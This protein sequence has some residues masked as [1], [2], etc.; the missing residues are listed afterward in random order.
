MPGKETLNAKSS[1]GESGLN[2]ETTSEGQ[3]PDQNMNPGESSVTAVALPQQ[4]L[5]PEENQDADL[6]K[7]YVDL[8]GGLDGPPEQGP[9]HEPI[10]VEKEDNG[11]KD[12]EEADAFLLPESGNFAIGTAEYFTEK[13]RFNGL[14]WRHEVK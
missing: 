1:A 9:H 11:D 8:Y 10:D 12:N 6:I 2:T 4:G 5:T 3:A 13:L 14:R 7:A